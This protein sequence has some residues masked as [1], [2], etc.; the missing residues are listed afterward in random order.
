MTTAADLNVLPAGDQQNMRSLVK[1]RRT[2]IGVPTG[3]RKPAKPAP[4]LKSRNLSNRR[5]FGG[6]WNRCSSDCTRHVTAPRRRSRD[7]RFAIALGERAATI[8]SS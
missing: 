2:R 5:S 8:A 3:S 4:R 6:R 7:N 1:T